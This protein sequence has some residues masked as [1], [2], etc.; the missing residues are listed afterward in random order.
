MVVWYRKIKVRLI[1]AC[2]QFLTPKTHIKKPL[3]DGEILS[4]CSGFHY[5][6]PIFDRM[7]VD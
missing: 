5:F 2:G 7:P 3:H 6:Y 1:A 4:A